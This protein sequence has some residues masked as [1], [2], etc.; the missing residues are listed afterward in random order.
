[1]FF[2]EEIASISCEAGMLCPILSLLTKHQGSSPGFRFFARVPDFF[3]GSTMNFAFT[4]TI[5]FRK[6]FAEAS[7]KHPSFL[8]EYLFYLPVFQYIISKMGG[9]L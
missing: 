3:A 2:I 5:T 9:I 4:I 1:M 7:Q 6:A 8:M